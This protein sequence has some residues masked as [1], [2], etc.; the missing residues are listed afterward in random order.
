MYNTS[1]KSQH[2]F[3]MCAFLVFPHRVYVVVTAVDNTKAIITAEKFSR[4]LKVKE[5]HVS[6]NV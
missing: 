3:G 5:Y 2:A 6:T 4:N 1:R